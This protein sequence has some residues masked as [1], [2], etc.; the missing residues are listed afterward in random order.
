LALLLSASV[1]QPNIG[2]TQVVESSPIVQAASA[3]VL[4]SLG[5]SA[6]TVT[7]TDTKEYVKAYFADIPILAEIAHCESRFTQFLKS[8]DVLRGEVDPD[9][10]GVMQINEKYNGNTAQALGYNIYTLEGNLAFGRWLYEHKGT[11]P[12]SASQGCWDR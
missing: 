12:W 7:A 9:D 5:A 3:D 6:I 8:G 1:N 4:Q 2:Q 10:V 11:Q